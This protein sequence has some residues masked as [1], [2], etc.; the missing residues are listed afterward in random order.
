M[1]TS[2]WE[3]IWHGFV[4]TANAEDAAVTA[5]RLIMYIISAFFV[6]FFSLP[7]YCHLVFS[8]FSLTPYCCAT[9]SMDS[10]TANEEW[11][12]ICMED[13][14]ILREY[15]LPDHD[16]CPRFQ[17][18]SD[19][20]LIFQVCTLSP[21]FCSRILTLFIRNITAYSVFISHVCLQHSMV[22]AHFCMASQTT[23][24]SNSRIA[25]VPTRTSSPSLSS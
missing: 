21:L 22:L 24:R 13:G 19:G 23:S 5:S 20:N 8:L 3:D 25:F 7:P 15:G 2:S 16:Y 10:D 1:L 11:V 9:C 14:I 4:N 18:A 6:F 12:R 17:Y